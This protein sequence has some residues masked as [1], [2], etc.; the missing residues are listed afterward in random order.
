MVD[1]QLGWATTWLG[2]VSK[3]MFTTSKGYKGWVHT[4]NHGR[5][6][7]GVDIRGEVDDLDDVE[8]VEALV[9]LHSLVNTTNPG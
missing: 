4:T 9:R 5:D 3:V 2:L 7:V 6:G 1:S 8:G